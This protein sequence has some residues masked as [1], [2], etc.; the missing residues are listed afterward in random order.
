VRGTDGT[1]WNNNRPDFIAFGLQVN[2][3][4]FELHLDDTSNILSDDP[5]G[6]CFGN[7]AQHLRPEVTVICL[8]SSLSGAGKRLAGEAPGK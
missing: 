6:P 5:S 8:A 7:N 4:A 2:T 1:S 3:H